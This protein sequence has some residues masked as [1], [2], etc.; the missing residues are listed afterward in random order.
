MRMQHCISEPSLLI[1]QM[2]R[3]V[4]HSTMCDAVIRGAFKSFPSRTHSYCRQVFA[5][6]PCE[7]YSYS[8]SSASPLYKQS[9]QS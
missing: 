3:L 2:Q 4:C 6:Q 7:E 1:R 8:V 9:G 5:A